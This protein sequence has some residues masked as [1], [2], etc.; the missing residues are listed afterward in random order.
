MYGWK[1]KSMIHIY[2]GMIFF[3]AKTE[4][5]IKWSNFL[6]WT[7]MLCL[8][9][10]AKNT[11]SKIW[12]KMRNICYRVKNTNEAQINR[13]FITLW[14]IATIIHFTRNVFL[15][16]FRPHDEGR[17][18]EPFEPLINTIFPLLHCSWHLNWFIIIFKKFMTVIDIRLKGI[19]FFWD[20]YLKWNLFQEHRAN[21]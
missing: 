18:H 10:G 19:A 17:R 6:N 12:N 3:A 14:V 9:L 8:N 2:A 13:L 7:I 11:I 5:K 1:T 4:M 15:L 16:S 20:I 21:Q